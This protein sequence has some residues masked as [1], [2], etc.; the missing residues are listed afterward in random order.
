LDGIILLIRQSDQASQHQNKFNKWHSNH[1]VTFFQMLLFSTACQEVEVFVEMN[2]NSSIFLKI[3]KIS[4]AEIFQN[5]F[6]CK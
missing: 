6:S 2:R 1:S 4:I 5:I 3:N